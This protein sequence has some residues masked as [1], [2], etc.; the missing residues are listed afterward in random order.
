MQRARGSGYA[1]GKKAAKSSVRLCDFAYD[2]RQQQL[3]NRCPARTRLVCLST[4]M[5]RH[6]ARYS[7][8]EEVVSL[9]SGVMGLLTG[10][11]QISFSEPSSFTIRLS[12]GER[13]V[14]APEY[15]E[16]APDDVMADPVSYTR[17]SSYRAA[18]EG[19]AICRSCEQT[20]SPQC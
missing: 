10:P 8:K 1:W 16:S 2:V 11:H 17:A 6:E 14:F 5:H 3:R 12:E 19:L 15:A 9:T 4:C 20:T 18:T 7:P 13:P